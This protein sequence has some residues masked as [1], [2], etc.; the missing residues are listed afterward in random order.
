M[1]LSR[2]PVVLFHP[3]PRLMPSLLSHDQGSQLC[4]PGADS[5]KGT[6][7]SA[8]ASIPPP[9]PGLGSLEATLHLLGHGKQL[10]GLREA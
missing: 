2:L 10:H 7:G 9:P 3:L 6:L 8:P 1:A 4:P 5:A